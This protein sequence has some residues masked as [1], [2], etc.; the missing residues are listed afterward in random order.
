[1][2][3]QVEASIVV[4]S[5]SFGSGR[6]DPT[7]EL[8]A[9]GYEVIRADHRHEP[10]ALA[11]SLATAVA[12]IAGTGPIGPAHL[13][14]APRLRIIARYGVGTDG[15]DRSE[16]ARRGIVLTNTPG[17]NTEAVADHTLGLILALLRGT[18]LGDRSVREGTP[19]PPPGREL[20]ECTVALIGVGAIGRAV[21][22]R[23]SAFGSRLVAH[24]PYV[25]PASLPEVEFLDLEQLA[26]VADIVSLHRPHADVPVIDEPFL[27][28]LRAGAV[29]VNTARASLVDEAA[30]ADA[31]TAGRLA[32]AALDVHS[33][34]RSRSGPLLSAPN[35]ILTPHLS[36]HTLEAIDR[37]GRT[38]TEEVLRALRGETPRHVVPVPG[39]EPQH[40]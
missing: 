36:G 33:S 23:L 35:V 10:D 22:Q 7:D 24:D 34:E 39:P 26:A 17:A 21:L 40:Q 37:M 25:D 8:R 11:G 19:P 2:T 18:L 31:L 30:I 1:V 6:T 20:G 3:R 16:L 15:I 5:R 29:L 4:T 14:L 32:G 9:A 38:A 28:R 12:W 27:R 13:A